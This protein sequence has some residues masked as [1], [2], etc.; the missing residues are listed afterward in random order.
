MLLKRFVVIALGLSFFSCKGGVPDSELVAKVNGEG[1]TKVDFDAAVERNMSRYRGQGHELPPG[2]EQRIQES[3]LRR[4]IDDKVIALKAKEFSVVVAPDEIEA[5]F[6]EHKDRFRTE[7]A[8]TD[9]LQ[10]SNNTVENM[11]ADLDRNLL[12]DRVVEKMSG[13]IDVT[14]ADIAKYYEENIQRFKEKEQVKGARIVVKV[15][16]NAPAKETQA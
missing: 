5:K 2:I 12:R 15:E 6:K 14:D 8:F 11:K 4:L 13:A 1:I 10:R 7:Q 3:V 9:Y 16:A